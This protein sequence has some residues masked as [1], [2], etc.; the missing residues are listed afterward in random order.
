MS[1]LEKV[2]ESRTKLKEDF[3]PETLV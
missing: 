1:Y 3:R 2:V